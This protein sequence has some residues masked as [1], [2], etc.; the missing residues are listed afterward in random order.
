MQVTE[1]PERV[2]EYTDECKA[3]LSWLVPDKWLSTEEFDR[4]S[5]EL[6]ADPS[7]WTNQ[8]HYEASCELAK[9]FDTTRAALEE[10]QAAGIVESEA[11]NGMVHYRLKQN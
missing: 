10:L 11:M 3:I 2:R 5:K 4:L 9:W 1:M 7:R 8:A 6:R